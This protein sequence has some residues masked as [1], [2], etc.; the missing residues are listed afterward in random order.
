MGAARPLIHPSRQPSR[1]DDRSIESISD[2]ACAQAP[3]L[4]ARTASAGRPLHFPR[5]RFRRRIRST[6]RW[7]SRRRVHP[8]TYLP[9]PFRPNPKPISNR[10]DRRAP[11]PSTSRLV[12]FDRRLAQARPRQLSPNVRAR[13]RRFEVGRRFRR[14]AGVGPRLGTIFRACPRAPTPRSLLGWRFSTLGA[15]RWAR[16]TWGGL[17]AHT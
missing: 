16:S 3:P 2:D 10:F 14:L 5:A 4:A 8:L 6:G 17:V 9:F 11:L 13:R 12:R 7:P 1:P 15:S